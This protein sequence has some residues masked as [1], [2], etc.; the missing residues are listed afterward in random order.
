[1]NISKANLLVRNKC[2]HASFAATPTQA[3]LVVF[4]QPY[5][6]HF[7]TRLFQARINA[8]IKKCTPLKQN[9]HFQ[10]A[11]SP[12]IP[13]KIGPEST[14][15]STTETTPESIPWSQEHPS[16]A[17]HPPG[18][19]D[20][21]AGTNTSSNTI[22]TATKTSTQVPT[23]ARRRPRPKHRRQHYVQREHDGDHVPV[24]QPPPLLTLFHDADIM[25]QKSERTFT[26]GV[27]YHLSR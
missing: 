15:E 16:P 27:H 7:S 1:M 3:P 26:G 22:T 18:D 20:L 10:K 19:H 12:R 2:L 5:H 23:R 17:F 14:T 13:P 11:R 6:V 24:S 25:G 9:Q 21:N 8:D 4:L